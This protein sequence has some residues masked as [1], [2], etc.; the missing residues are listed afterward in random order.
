MCSPMSVRVTPRCLR[1]APLGGNLIP[2]SGGGGD[3]PQASS[4]RSSLHHLTF[5]LTQAE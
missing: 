2:H 4:L 1:L 3:C 5:D